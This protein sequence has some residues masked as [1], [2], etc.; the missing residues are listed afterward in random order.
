MLRRI[1]APYQTGAYAP[2]SAAEAS[3]IYQVAIERNLNLGLARTAVPSHCSRV[4]VS[5]FCHSSAVRIRRPTLNPLSAQQKSLTAVLP[6]VLGS[7]QV[8]SALS[9]AEEE[10]KIPEFTRREQMCGQVPDLR[11]VLS[12]I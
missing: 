4:N 5:I 2:L 9:A 1:R 7:I 12:W 8:F 10:Q 11:C 3:A 6:I